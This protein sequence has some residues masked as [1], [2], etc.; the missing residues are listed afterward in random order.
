MIV[1]DSKSQFIV[2]IIT[3]VAEQKITLGNAAKILN[4]SKRTIERYLQRYHYAGIRFVIH[5]IKV[6]L[7]Q[8]KSLILLKKEFSN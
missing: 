7:L 4:K 8:I 2:D 3:K 1:M 6:N 5:K